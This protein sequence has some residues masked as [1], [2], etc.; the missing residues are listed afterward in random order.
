METEKRT[1]KVVDLFM[2]SRMS[3]GGANW[4]SQV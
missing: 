3:G 2:D 1:A 4:K